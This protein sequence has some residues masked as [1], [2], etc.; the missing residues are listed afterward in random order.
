MCSLERCNE[1]GGEPGWPIA[2][3]ATMQQRSDK[4]L[5][6][7]DIRIKPVKLLHPVL[8]PSGRPKLLL[9]VSALLILA[10]FLQPLNHLPN[11]NVMSMI[12]FAVW[13]APAVPLICVCLRAMMASPLSQVWALFLTVAA[14]WIGLCL[15]LLGSAFA[16]PGAAFISAVRGC[17]LTLAVCAGLLSLAP[18]APGERAEWLAV[19]GLMLASLLAIW[20]LLCVPLVLI[21]AERAAAGAPYCIAQHG[22][23]RSVDGFWDLRGFSFYTRDSGYK[24]NSGWYFHG[25]LIVEGAEGRQ[26][27]NWSPR[28][29]RFDRI[30]HPN[31]Y[32][33]SVRN[34][35]SP[36]LALKWDS[37]VTRYSSARSAVPGPRPFRM[38][39]PS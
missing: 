17:G 39:L 37:G 23:S 20:S 33:V 24:D 2:M 6:E 31:R 5:G 4:G 18:E 34:L 1:R 36:R 16:P 21:Q 22:P 28:H 25:V 38:A 19:S 8:F 10:G 9:L 14:F 32:S 35:C 3:A 15:T 26:Y 30:E 7:K 11:L 29:L 27:F 13:L 12:A